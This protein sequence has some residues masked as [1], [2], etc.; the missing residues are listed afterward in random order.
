MLGEALM[1]YAKRLGFG[2]LHIKIDAEKEL[3]AII[4]IHSTQR[5]PALGGCRFLEYASIDLALRDTMRLAQGMSYKAALANLPLGGGK[6]VLLRPKKIKDRNI[7]FQNLGKFINDLNGRYIVAMDS[8]VTTSDMDNIALET[9]Y[10]AT[11]PPGKEDPGPYTALGVLRG[12]AAAVK[13][14]FQQDTLGGLHVALQG[15]GNVGFSLANLLYQ[16]GVRLTVCDVNQ[17]VTRLCEKKF[18]AT[19]VNSEDIY[20]VECDIFSPCAL[21]AILNDE[22]IPQ[23]KARIVAGSANNQLAERRHANLLKEKGIL[24][25]P[26]Y[27]IN[28]GGLI[29]SYAEYFNTPNKKSVDH[30]IKKIYDSALQLFQR[31][32]Q[33]DKLPTEIADKIAHER[34][35]K[36]NVLASFSKELL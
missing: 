7:Y 24:Y 33:E 2:E 20:A 9:P 31:A 1:D 27:V 30:D 4:G 22:T 16:Q 32:Y 35:N 21:G 11:I 12:I 13:F 6:T 15:L 3:Y 23:L 34:L 10:V 18:G 28:V 5:G 17:E 8:G 19:V 25:A 36:P 29:Y 26:D 14:K